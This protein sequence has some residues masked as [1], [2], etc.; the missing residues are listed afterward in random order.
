MAKDGKKKKKLQK[1]SE[2]QKQRTKGYT[3]E[4]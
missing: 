4:V 2:I 1:T 3:S